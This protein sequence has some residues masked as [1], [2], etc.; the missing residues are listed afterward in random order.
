MERAH[1]GHLVRTVRA[2]L[3]AGVPLTVAAF[4]ACGAGG[5]AFAAT[6]DTVQQGSKAPAKTATT[7]AAPGRLS[8]EILAKVMQADRNLSKAG[9]RDIHLDMARA[10]NGTDDSF[11]QWQAQLESNPDTAEAIKSAGLTPKEYLRSYATIVQAAAI[12][13]SR[14]SGTPVPERI[15][16]QIAEADVAFV[17]AHRAEIGQMARP[18]A[19]NMTP[20]TMEDI[21]VADDSGK[22]AKPAAHPE[23]AGAGAA[24]AAGSSSSPDS[25]KPEARKKKKPAAT[26][27]H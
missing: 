24:P 26:K 2:G 27:G 17:D 20:N 10:L 14:Q 8:Q 5:S 6:A 11:T 18:G 12:A 4:V 23:N 15:T 13:N 25:A 9:P 22:T 16:R 21:Y 3:S 1:L 19:A 7:S